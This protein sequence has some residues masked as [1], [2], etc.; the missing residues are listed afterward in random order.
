MV[1]GKGRGRAGR[2]S[3]ILHTNGGIKE[4]SHGNA[5]R[6][7][8]RGNSAPLS[9]SEKLPR[10]GAGRAAG[11]RLQFSKRFGWRAGTASLQ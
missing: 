11:V 4:G 2:S 8:I 7:A 9:Y 3:E 5:S 1:V 10:G 6:M